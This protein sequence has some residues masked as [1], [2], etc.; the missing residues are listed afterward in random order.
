MVLLTWHSIL[1][2]GSWIIA[3]FSRPNSFAYWANIVAS[4]INGAVVALVA[5]R[6]I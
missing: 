4:A 3:G 2:V 6:M 5:Y 1:A